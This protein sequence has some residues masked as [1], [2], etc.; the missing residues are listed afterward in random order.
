MVY[1][2]MYYR[3]IRRSWLLWCWPV[4]WV[5][6]RRWTSSSDPMQTLIYNNR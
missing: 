2:Y 1:L 5:T 4:M 3:L 6:V